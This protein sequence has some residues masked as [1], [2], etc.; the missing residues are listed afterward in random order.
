MVGD[1]GEAL[2]LGPPMRGRLQARHSPADRV[3]SHG[4]DL[5]ASAR[6]LDLVPVDER[7]R[8]AP[9]TPA[10]LLRPQEPEAFVG[11]GREVISPA[12][13]TVV[14][15]HDGE[16]D[17][18]AHR[19]V[20]SLRYALTQ[21]GRL[22][23]GWAALAGNHL[24][25]RLAHEGGEVHLA[26]CHLQRGSILVRPARTV[27]PGDLL[28]RCGNSGNSTEPHLHLQ[29]MTTADPTTARAVAFD[30]PGGMPRNG[31]I[32]AL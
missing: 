9:L 15:V 7:G 31:R 26:L 28:A 10:A 11:F 14:R 22:A 25:L 20:P 12:E 13:G 6:A 32:I 16:V 2:R 8:S 29:V 5:F 19:G 23:Q 24:I 18:P 17:H 4:T 30:L 3:P 21:R 27:H 1:G